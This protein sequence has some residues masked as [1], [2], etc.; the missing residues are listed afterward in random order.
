MLSQAFGYILF[1]AAVLPIAFFLTFFKT[2]RFN[3]PFLP[4]IYIHISEFVANVCFCEWFTKVSIWILIFDATNY[5]NTAVYN[6]FEM[7]LKHLKTI[8]HAQ[9]NIDFYLINVTDK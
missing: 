8:L 7:Q 5:Y 3:L 2:S 4:N 9:V 1:E 6:L